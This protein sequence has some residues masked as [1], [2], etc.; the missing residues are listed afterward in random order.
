MTGDHEPEMLLFDVV[1]KVKLP[2]EQMAF[3]CVN[4]GVIG[5]LTV[6]TLAAEVEVHEPFDTVT[7][8]EPL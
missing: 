7:E 5:A 8:Y 1:G 3:I 4:D 2:P 6:T